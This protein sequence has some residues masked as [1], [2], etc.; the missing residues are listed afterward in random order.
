MNDAKG[1]TPDPD[2]P[3]CHGTGVDLGDM[4]GLARIVQAC[5]CV[6]GGTFDE[7]ES[8]LSPDARKRRQARMPMLS[9]GRGWQIAAK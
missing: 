9:G 1:P 5:H 6:K 7:L 2:C 8:W 4:D 3:N